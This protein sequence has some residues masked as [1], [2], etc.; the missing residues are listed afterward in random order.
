MGG[1]SL[2]QKGEATAALTLHR[3]AGGGTSGVLLDA[4]AVAQLFRSEAD[5]AGERSEYLT[6]FAADLR[7]LIRGVAVM[8]HSVESGGVRL[9]GM[10]VDPGR[11]SEA[12]QWV[13]TEMDVAAV[14]SADQANR[15]DLVTSGGHHA[16]LMIPFRASDEAP[17]CLSAVLA[18][19]R[20]DSVDLHLSV[21]RLA[22]LAVARRDAMV[23]LSEGEGILRQATMLVEML[24]LTARG[25][26]YRQA[27]QVLALELEKFFGCQRVAIGSGS[28]RLCQVQAVSGMNA[29]DKRTLGQAQ[30]ASAMREAIALGEM[31]VW[32]VQEDLAR[33][34]SISANQD[35]L[36]HSYKAGRILVLPLKQEEMGFS[37]ALALLWPTDAPLVAPRTLRLLEAC[38]PH[39]GAL[40]AMLHHSKPRSFGARCRKFWNGGPSRRVAVIAL[41]AASVGGLLFPI[42]YRVPAECRVEPLLRRTI[43]APFESRLEKTHVKPGDPVV[44]DQVIAELDGREIRV[45]LAEAIA[46]RSAALKKR[47]NAMV[48]SDAASQQMAQIEADRLDL[49]VQRLQFRNDHLMIRSPIDGV[50]LVGDLERSEGVPVAPGQ[51]LFEI[52]PLEGMVLEVSVPDKEVGHV[53]PGMA[54]HYRLESDGGRKRVATVEK[55]SPAAELVDDQH[56][57]IAEAGLGNADGFLRPG[58]KGEARIVSGKKPVG[59]IFF[60]GLW[61]YL[62]LKLW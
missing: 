13:P 10:A 36:L 54:V 52:A 58:M 45:A 57:F 31:T 18:P 62:R 46:E 26:S 39:F 44:K 25:E 35:D 56:V 17:I 24:S 6:G 22:T 40:V 59:W 43:A 37:G 29:G 7:Q 51:K 12:S 49:E 34:V 16:R 47:D 2:E 50:I 15:V 48:L 1:D 32:P 3:A 20:A 61:E 23:R 28:S 4:D 11:Q 9:L 55:L 38:Q 5:L 30:L 27:L 14:M 8:V 42:R 53:Q 60:H 41:V 21:I 19:E 33:E